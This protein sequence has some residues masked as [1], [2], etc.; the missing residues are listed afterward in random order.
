MNLTA[1]QKKNNHQSKIILLRFETKILLCFFFVDLYLT[2][3]TFNKYKQ[4]EVTRHTC[5][6]NTSGSQDLFSQLTSKSSSKSKFL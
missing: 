4:I 2:P 3:V 1:F 5:R 6:Y